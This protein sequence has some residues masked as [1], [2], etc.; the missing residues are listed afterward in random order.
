MLSCAFEV[1]S[2]AGRYGKSRRRDDAAEGHLRLSTASRYW[3]HVQSLMQEN[4]EEE[5]AIDPT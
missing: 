5:C 4:T 1:G 3:T 2:A